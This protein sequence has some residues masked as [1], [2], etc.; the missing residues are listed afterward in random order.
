M[1]IKIALGFIIPI[2]VLYLLYALVALDPYWVLHVS[3]KTRIGFVLFLLPSV[4]GSI[5]AIVNKK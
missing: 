4:A 1:K 3:E 5:M 2:I